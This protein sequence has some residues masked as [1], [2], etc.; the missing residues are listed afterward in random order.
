MPVQTRRNKKVAT[1]AI[2]G[3][4]VGDVRRGLDFIRRQYMEHRD[5]FHTRMLI[6]GTGLTIEQFCYLFV[7]GTH[8][9]RQQRS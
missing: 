9:K 5:T 4:S 7:E 2:P 3:L 8:S 6:E 1:S